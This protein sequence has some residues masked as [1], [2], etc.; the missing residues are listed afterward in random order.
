MKMNR[1]KKGFT[2]IE[3][4]VVVAIIGLLASV[5]LA[6]LNSAR[7]KAR[8]ARRKEDIHQIQ[9]AL[10]LYY[11]T[12]GQY[13]GT[14]GLGLP[15]T[16]PNSSWFNSAD[17]SWTNFQTALA[18]YIATVPK[19]PIENNNAAQWAS[20]GY[21]YSY[22]SGV[23]QN[24]CATQQYYYLVYQLENTS[25]PDNGFTLCDGTVIRYG[26]AGAN[27]AVKTVGPA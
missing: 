2:L 20:T 7:G 18:P 27:T 26:G 8:D 25:G 13:P 24:G 22:Y 6:S 11:S 19:D 3:L 17:G 4:L 15:G 1:C 21:H 10:A 16:Q 14:S 9:I 5:V 23:A 12:N